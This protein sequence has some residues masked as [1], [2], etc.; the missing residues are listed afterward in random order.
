VRTARIWI[1]AA[2][3]RDRI[4]V[5]QPVAG[6]ELLSDTAA[7]QLLHGGDLIIPWRIALAAAD[8]LDDEGERDM[9]LRRALP[10]W[11]GPDDIEFVLDVVDAAHLPKRTPLR[12]RLGFEGVAGRPGF[13]LVG[14]WVGGGGRVV[15]ELPEIRVGTICNRGDTPRRLTLGQFDALAAL[16]NV[17]GLGQNR[18]RDLEQQARL[19][20]AVPV[21]DH[22]VYFDRALEMNQVSVVT[23]VAP[24]LAPSGTGYQVRPVLPG[25]LQ[26]R[27]EDYFYDTPR[28]EL[29]ERPLV[30]RDGDVRT[31]TVFTEE[32][33]D[34]LRACRALNEITAE[35]AAHA[36]SHPREFFG[37]TLDLAELSERVTGLGP[38]VRAM[39]PVLR[40]L[41]SQ[42]WWDW[43]MPLSFGDESSLD[44]AAET[45][46]NLKD[47]VTRTRLRAALEGADQRGDTFIPALSGG[48]FIPITEQLREAVQV[49]DTLADTVPEPVRQDRVPREVLR[50]LENVE[51]LAFARAQEARPVERLALEPP[52]G[53]KASLFAYQRDGFEWL[54]SLYHAARGDQ[55]QWHGAVLADDMGL[56]K[57]LQVLSFMAWRRQ[58]GGAGP[59]LV[60]APVAL[61]ENWQREAQRFFGYLHEPI[62]QVIGRDLPD[63]AAVAAERLRSQH[64]VLV[65][66]ET[67]KQ[68]EA[69]FARVPWDVVVLDEAQKAKDPA[70]QVARVVRTLKAHFR[71]A[72]TGTPVENS[73]RELWTLYDWAT[74]GLLGSL[75]TFADEFIKPIQLGAASA[76]LAEALHERI[77]PVFLRRLKKHELEGLPPI[78]HQRTEVAMSPEQDALYSAIMTADRSRSSMD[79]LGRLL[80]LFAV[81]A[82]PRL[83][84]VDENEDLPTRS[85]VDFPRARTTFEIL[86]KVKAQGEKALIFANRKRVQR[87]LAREIEA[88]FGVGVDVINGDL[89]NSKGRLKRIDVFSAAPGFGALVLAPRAAGVGLNITAANHVIHYTREWNP[90]VENQATDRAY[91]LGQQRP[92]HVH[93]LVATSPHGSTVDVRLD[94]LLTAKR[95]L[96][97]NFVV[98]MGGFD[99]RTD[100]FTA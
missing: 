45:A 26:E 87:W 52:P 6:V 67:L 94:E 51:S 95:G 35:D 89:D 50:V 25:V 75:R 32:A 3:D 38:P 44:G 69:I 98:P 57:T 41:K 93:Y 81:L 8:L 1:G 17:T 30:A 55:Q 63:D 5:E 91:R 72:M 48:G 65:S 34:G 88:R 29:G 47:E 22:G 11:L 56:G 36:L 61:L 76:P 27:S 96:M 64:L 77:R 70:T 40:E 9:V 39:Y 99:I 16:M 79:A 49:A 37:A 10:P 80:R 7:Q 68:K 2:E 46:L 73:L 14:A 82:H 85:E 71:L 54:A 86:E 24:K 4:L 15:R 42:S 97:D 100:D 43:D 92:V 62:L 31:R 83:A 58:T 59:H 84:S 90:A 74:P 78:H 60:V 23:A 19:C 28:G 18:S 33:I 13:G 20:A 21:G 12:L 53:L 66:Y